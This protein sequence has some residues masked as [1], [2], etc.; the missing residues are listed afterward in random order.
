[1]SPCGTRYLALTFSTL[2]SSQGSGAHRSRVSR[3]FSGQLAEP[4][5]VPGA[6]QTSRSDLR[7]VGC[8]SARQ[9]RGTSH[10]VASRDRP[11]ADAQLVSGA[12]GAWTKVRVARAGVKW[13][14]HVDEVAE[15]T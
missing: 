2:L 6:G 15:L 3:P 9:C 7:R 11:P 1:M 4:T 5:C 13:N 8:A 12:P 14:P 10:G